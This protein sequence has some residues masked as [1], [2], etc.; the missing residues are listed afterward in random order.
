MTCSEIW[1]VQQVLLSAQH[2]FARKPEHAQH[3]LE[4]HSTAQRGLLCLI[5]LLVVSERYMTQNPFFTAAIAQS[6]AAE[7]SAERPRNKL[8]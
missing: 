5:C 2:C 4:Q 1:D 6:V 8:A 7:L 3:G